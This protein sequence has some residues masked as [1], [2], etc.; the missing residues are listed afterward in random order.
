MWN[1]GKQRAVGTAANPFGP[2]SVG[3]GCSTVCAADIG[4]VIAGKNKWKIHQAAFAYRYKHIP[5]NE[6]NGTANSSRSSETWV[7]AHNCGRDDC[8]V[9][10]HMSVVH[11]KHNLI[12]VRC[13]AALKKQERND[14]LHRK[15]VSF[16]L[17]ENC[18]WIHAGPQCFYNCSNKH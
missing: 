9:T 8:S 6:H 11:H 1:L 16:V 4:M 10:D 13:H 15:N 12:Q 17:S 3:G 5:F 14:R 2:C 18:F 7:I